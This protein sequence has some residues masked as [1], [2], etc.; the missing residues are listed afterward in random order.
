MKLENIPATQEI[1]NCGTATERIC[2]FLDFHIQPLV[3]FVPSVIKDTTHFLRKL[4]KLGHIP[5]T[6]IL[7][8][9]YVMG[10]NFIYS[11]TTPERIGCI[12]KRYLI[13]GEELPVDDLID[14]AKLGLEN[15]YFEFEDKVYQQKLGTAIGTKFAPGFANIFMGDWEERFLETCSICP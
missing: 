8:T 7:C 3:K 15:N 1:S 4:S 14:L 10:F 2:E 9:V 12:E 6:V 5:K 13:G 11:Y